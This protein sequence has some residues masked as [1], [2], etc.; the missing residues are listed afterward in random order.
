[1]Y[2]IRGQYKTGSMLMAAPRIKIIRKHQYQQW[3][4]STGWWSNVQDERQILIKKCM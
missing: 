1:M 3:C 2:Y 4:F